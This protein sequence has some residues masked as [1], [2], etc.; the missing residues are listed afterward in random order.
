MIVKDQN[1]ANHYG[2]VLRSIQYYKNGNPK[3]TPKQ[4]EQKK[5]LY[6]AMLAFY[7]NEKG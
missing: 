7:R 5:R 3:A 2:V 4:N 1:L 6:D